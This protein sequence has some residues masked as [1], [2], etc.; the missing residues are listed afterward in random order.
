MTVGAVIPPAALRAAGR[1]ERIAAYRVRLPLDVPLAHSAVETA[2]L[3]E[4][5][6]VL[7]GEGGH[8][9]FAEVRG[10]GAYAT[11][12]DADG[13]LAGLS[14]VASGLLGRPL[15]EAAERATSA[16]SMVRLVLEGAALDAVGRAAGLPAWRLL[17]ATGAG[18]ME[19]HAGLPFL[20]PD[21]T[22][23]LAAGLAARGFRRFKLRVGGGRLEGDVERALAVRHAVPDAELAVDANGAWETEQALEA[24]ALLAPAGLSWMEQ[25]T[26]PGDLDALRAVTQVA[27]IPVVADEGIVGEEDVAALVSARAATGV[28]LKLEKAGSIAA[29]A[30]AAAAA[31]AAGLFVE[32]GQMD[33]GRTGCALTAAAAAA[34]PADAYELAGFLHLAHDVATG[35]EVFAGAVTLGSAPG[36][37]VEVQLPPDALELEVTHG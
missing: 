15:G 12:C 31:R 10:N 36:L 19:T 16:P 24:L 32:L 34:V 7:E 5:F 22:G 28:H 20:D 26:A 37:G 1:L 3:E 30:G 23:A 9:G 18:P 13:I 6:V 2:A 21:A 11:G 33:Q 8:R 35:L 29:V 14:E 4:V 25:P 17:G 27:D